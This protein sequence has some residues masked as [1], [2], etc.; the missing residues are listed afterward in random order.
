[1][2]FAIQRVSY[3]SFVRTF[4]RVLMEVHPDQSDNLLPFTLLA[5]PR[6]GT[7][8]P[9]LSDSFSLFE[10]WYTRLTFAHSICDLQ[11]T[12]IRSEDNVLIESVWFLR[13]CFTEVPRRRDVLTSHEHPQLL[14]VDQSTVRFLRER[15]F[16][17]VS[18]FMFQRSEPFSLQRSYVHFQYVPIEFVLRDM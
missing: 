8:Q 7:V 13:K 18:Q 10:Y 14:Y 9:H 6:D 12:L 1:M 17:F 16:L 3:Q 2:D 4:L 15:D 11:E 5:H